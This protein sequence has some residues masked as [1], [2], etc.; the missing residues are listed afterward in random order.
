MPRDTKE[1]WKTISRC[2]RQCL[3]K[4]SDNYY[5]A[6]LYLL[7]TIERKDLRFATIVEVGNSAGLFGIIKAYK[8]TEIY[9]SEMLT[10]LDPNFALKG[11]IKYLQKYCVLENN[12]YVPDEYQC[13]YCDAAVCILIISAS[14]IKGGQKSLRKELYGYC[15][16]LWDYIENKK[17]NKISK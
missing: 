2:N 5:I 7:H 10:E 15:R 17:K 11:M 1:I 12:K 3:C 13:H 8:K 16:M 14:N 6:L 4:S 9:L